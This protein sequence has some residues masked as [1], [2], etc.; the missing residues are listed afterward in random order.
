[1]YYLNHTG[2]SWHGNYGAGLTV[3]QGYRGNLIRNPTTGK[4]EQMQYGLRKW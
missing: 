2:F 1:M 4:E 3:K